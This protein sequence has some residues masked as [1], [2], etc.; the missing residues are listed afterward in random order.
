[1]FRRVLLGAACAAVAV[2]AFAPTLGFAGASCRPLPPCA[3]FHAVYLLTFVF[4]AGKPA[5]AP[6]SAALKSA[7]TVRAARLPGAATLRA[8]EATLPA[9]VKPGVVT[10][11]AYK[12]LLTYAKE[13]GFAM[14]GASLMQCFVGCA[15]R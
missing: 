6:R 11:Q 14:P 4:S 15:L 8:A 13:K 9:T 2:D 10:G 5:L 7:P 3:L 1:M 12:D